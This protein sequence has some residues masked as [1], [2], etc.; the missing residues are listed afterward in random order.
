MPSNA[1]ADTLKNANEGKERMLAVLPPFHIYA[2]TVNMLFGLRLGAEV[3][4]HVRF[5]PKAALAD[6][7]GQKVSI[8][9]CA[10]VMV[11]SCSARRFSSSFFAF[12]AASRFARCSAC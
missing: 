12:S 5:D 9:R 6:I 3:I 1:F 4:Q 10:A 8:S 2:L 11:R 7:S